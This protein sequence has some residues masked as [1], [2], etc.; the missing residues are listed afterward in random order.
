MNKTFHILSLITL[1]SFISERMELLYS[2]ALSFFSLLTREKYFRGIKRNKKIRPTYFLRSDVRQ[3]RVILST[4]TKCLLK[5]QFW[6][7]R[8]S[9]L[10]DV[11]LLK[12]MAISFRA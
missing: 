2:G 5:P 1:R 4:E 8:L 6:L 10:F 3:G 9:L 7:Y 11:K 12:D